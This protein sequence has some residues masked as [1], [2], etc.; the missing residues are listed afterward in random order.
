MPHLHKLS[1]RQALLRGIAGLCVAGCT[2]PDQTMVGPGAVSQILVL[3][4]SVTVDPG[5]SLQFRAVGLT[6]TG[7]TEPVGVRWMATG[8]GR[9]DDNGIYVADDHPGHY[10]VRAVLD[11]P[12]LVAGAGVKNR[13]ALKQ[14]VLNPSSANVPPG[15]QAQFSA[16]GTLANGDVVPVSV[17]Y[18]ATYGSVTAYGLYTAGQNEGTYQLMA[19][20]GSG[21]KALADTATIA[22]S[23][24][25]PPTLTRVVLEP[26]EAAVAA[27]G[28]QQ[29]AAYGRL[30]NGDSVAVGVTYTATG[31]TVTAGG[32]Y[33]AGQ[34]TGSYRV[35]ATESGGAV[36]DTSTVTIVT[37]TPMVTSVVLAPASA[38]LT[39]GGTQQFTAYARLSNGDSGAV[40]VTYI[41]SGGTITGDGL[42]TAGQTA[43]P[44][45]VIA[46]QS[47]GTLADTSSVLI[48]SSPVASVQVTPSDATLA[49]GTGLQ[50]QV[51]L[52]DANGATLSG[53]TVTWASSNTAAATV[54]AEGS[55]L[56]VD[57]G[58]A[59]I[60]ATCEGKSGTAT[61]MVTA[62][63][64]GCTGS[65]P[66]AVYPRMPLSTGQAFYVSSASG[67]D[68]N[69]GTITAPWKTL[70]KAFDALQPGQIAYLREGAYGAFCSASQFTRAGTAS[71]PITVRGYPGERAVL[72]GQIRLE[73]SYFRLAHVVV[74]GPSCGTWGASTQQGD[75]LVLMVPGTTHHVEV[76]NSE[77]YHGGW[78]AGIAAGGDDIW[79]LN[80]Y[81]HDNGG[82]NDPN[83]YN[84]SHGIYYHDGTRGV[85]ANNILEH[86]RAKG[87]SARYSAN[88]IIV[89]NNTVVGNGRSGMDIA[90]NTHDWL[91]A[92]NIVA[93]NGNVNDGVGIH[94]SGSS[95]GT[96]NIEINNVL[97]NNG[98]SG[99]SN[100]D[101]DATII[102][103]KVADPL[104][105]SPVS[106]VPSTTHQGFTNDYH[107]RSGSPAIDFASATYALPFDLGGV[108]RPLGAGPDAGV[109]EN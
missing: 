3:P 42:Y 79:I 83:Q 46:A 81:I 54:S 72:H 107:V 4:E 109:Y 106:S 19:I 31:G 22:I 50:L 58:T 88:H 34:T 55:V 11:R 41:A 48:T 20:A 98:V 108:C 91:F 76:S 37:G 92:N 10:E 71:G 35:V 74:E 24:N 95:G 104:L 77:V 18:V 9:I 94:T 97:W 66:A 80:N 32:L 105:V 103:N 99:T 57:A 62:P 2:V 8:G 78:H 7:A 53:R 73:G 75:N 39:A 36:A 70:Q 15:G 40:S 56:A 1:A 60:T 68:A 27:G 26:P 17:A 45:S 96:S 33:T 52:K 90:E 12:N 47:G 101:T 84:T 29:F 87:L 14:V 16:S 102:N 89:A 59:T 64:S 82:F 25:A 100:W 6:T 13:G 30:S 43:G 5:Q 69:P 93:N 23:S 38:A 49:I 63:P 28:T 67:S 51:T 44:Y 61:I 65:W 21:N 85:V 86:N